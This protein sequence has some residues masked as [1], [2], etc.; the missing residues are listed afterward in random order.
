MKL[1]PQQAPLYGRCVI[2]VQLADEELDAAAK[3]EEGVDFFL[4]FAGSTQ[5][6]LTSTFRS[7]HDTLQALCPAHDCC[8]VVSVTL[9]SASRG[10]PEAPE[11]PKPRLGRVSPL[12][13]HP[14]SFVQDVAFDMAQFLVSTAGRADGLDG[15]L[16]LDECQI[17]LQ[18]C[19]RLDESLALA[20]QHLALP[21][22][23]SLLGNKLPNSNGP[24]PQE[25]LLHFSARRGLLRVTRFLLQQAGAGD[26]LRLANRQGHTPSAVAA[27]RGHERLHELLTQAET[28]NGAETV[29]LVSTD[30]RIACHLPTLNT[31][32]LTLSDR[33]GHAPPALRRSVEQLL[34]SIRRL[35]AETSEVPPQEH[36]PGT[37]VDRVCLGSNTGRARCQSLSLRD[38]SEG[39]QSVEEGAS[40]TVGSP[41]PAGRDKR[42]EDTDRGEAAIR[43]GQEAKK[44]EDRSEQEA[45]DRTATRREEATALIKPCGDTQAAVMGQSPSTEGSG[46]SDISNPEMKEPQEGGRLRPEPCD[47]LCFLEEKA[48][49]EGL[50]DPV[51]DPG[52]L[53]DPPPTA[54]GDVTG[55]PDSVPRLLIEGLHEGEPPP[56]VNSLEQNQEAAGG[57]YATERAWAWA[58]ETGNGT[59][60]ESGEEL[61]GEDA[62]EPGP[63]NR[64]DGTCLPME[65]PGGAADN[66][67]A[68]DRTGDQS[69]GATSSAG[70]R[71]ADHDRGTAH[72]VSSDDEDSFRS[73]GSSTT[74]I[75]HPTL[76]G[77]LMEDQT[78]PPSAGLTM[79]EPSGP[80]QRQGDEPESEPSPSLDAPEAST[81][82]VSPGQTWAESGDASDS[83]PNTGTVTAGVWF[84][85]KETRDESSPASAER[86]GELDTSKMT[87]EERSPHGGQNTEEEPPSRR[88]ESDVTD[89]ADGALQGRSGAD[90]E[91]EV[92]MSGGTVIGAREEENVPLEE[93]AVSVIH[94]DR[95]ASFHQPC[96]TQHSESSGPPALPSLPSRTS[97]ATSCPSAAHT[98]SGSDFECLL[99]AEP[100]HD[101]VFRKNDE[102]VTGRDSASEVSVSCSST[103]DAASVGPSSS[104][105]E[106]SQGPECSWSPQ[107]AGPAI[108][109]GLDSVGA[110]D[111]GAGE[112]EEEAKDRVTE[113]PRR[114]SILRSSIRSLSPLRRHSWGPGKNNGGDAEM[115]QRSYSLEGLSGAQEEL[116]GP[117]AQGPRIQEPSRMPRHD[118][119]DG[120]SLV[121][122][123][124]EQEGLGQHGRLQDLK[125][126]RYRPLRNSCPPMTL[127]LTKSVSMLAISQRDLDGMRSFGSASGSLAYSISEEEPGPLRS[128]TD[129]KS[130]TKVSRTFSY[131]K[132]KMYKKTRGKS[133]TLFR[134]PSAHVVF[135]PAAF[136]LSQ[137]GICGVKDV[138]KVM[139]LSCFEPVIYRPKTFGAVKVLIHIGQII[140]RDRKNSSLSLQCCTFRNS[141]TQNQSTESQE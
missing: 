140:L 63:G 110:G 11:N 60:T 112:A 80:N 8:E 138:V 77:A 105:P 126:R 87:A 16:L 76:D 137:T 37:P 94:R 68:A 28:Y 50:T 70:T 1:N 17:S 19:E 51:S 5:R 125:S 72:G 10:V 75:F 132:N 108:A 69:P 65:E 71:L 41:P 33:P 48:V 100:G 83:Q 20:L 73:V 79:E 27:L 15:A 13:E 128:D 49:G 82:D 18:E 59:R 133:M 109:A 90:R 2:T 104:S 35:R 55:E 61:D 45:E 131:L 67:T 92:I 54:R 117:A 78:D 12:A 74:E 66:R 64:I 102:P 46:G 43:R 123:T 32:T 22:G 96:N 84:E 4:L 52:G 7:S 3:E 107:E 91:V 136:S 30:A 93:T 119:V 56:G 89:V 124:V 36:G 95:E 98:D 106:G 99:N 114:S 130:T 141:V 26:A 23:W 118:S 127:P 58:P 34:H 47:A 97:S 81:E 31:H 62:A 88:A 38:G 42:A 122:L 115:N 6:H 25:T 86:S 121:S 29:Q 103:D 111:G 57:D 9:C 129:G 21:P 135:S 120:G 44:G 101:S 39:A 85:P 14:F 139:S 116:R 134:F 40:L 53:P 24:N 113:V